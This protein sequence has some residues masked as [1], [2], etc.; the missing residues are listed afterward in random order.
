M[1]S[2]SSK[3]G[4]RSTTTSRPSAPAGRNSG[5]GIRRGER[6]MP[7]AIDPQVEEALAMFAVDQVKAT[8]AAKGAEGFHDLRTGDADTDAAFAGGGA[9]RLSSTADRK[10]IVYHQPDN[11]PRE[12]LITQLR[13]TLR[14]RGLDGRAIFGM[15]P[16]GPY[17]Q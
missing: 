2:T 11:E 16:N 6:F 14:K 15:Q 5:T 12:I 4:G 3:P 8:I 1:P 7:T 10:V 17:I 13:S 9:M